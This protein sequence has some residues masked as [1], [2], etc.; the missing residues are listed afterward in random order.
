[1]SDRPQLRA[2]GQPHILIKDIPGLRQ[3]AHVPGSQGKAGLSVC[4]GLPASGGLPATR[5]PRGSQGGWF[6][7]AGTPEAGPELGAQA[8]MPMGTAVA[9]R[10]QPRAEGGGVRA[11]GAHG[12]LWGRARSAASP[13][14]G[15]CV[16]RGDSKTG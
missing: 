5:G 7:S 2:S 1:M 9:G 12:V 14:D 8:R 11:P 3:G 15:V 6:R 13:A 4:T 10:T 16:S